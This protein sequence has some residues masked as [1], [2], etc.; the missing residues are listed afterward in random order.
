MYK[1]VPAD[2]ERLVDGLRYCILVHDADTKEILWA[3]KAATDLLGFTVEEL[4]PLKAP[5]MS[6]QE[7][8]YRRSVGRRWLQDAVDNGVA[9]IEWAYRSKS[10]RVILSEAIAVHVDLA[11]RS[12]VM[13]QFRDIEQEAMTRR[14]LTRTE[15][16]LTRT[17][18]RLAAFLRNMAEGILVLDD[19]SR[20]SYASEAAAALLKVPVTSLIGSDFTSF[21][22]TGPSQDHIRRALIATTA[23]GTPQSLRYEVDLPGG[24]RRWHAASCQHIS[25][26]NDLSGHLVLF[27]DITDRVRTEQ[28]HERDSQYLNYLARYNAMGDMAMAIAHELAQP[29]AAATNFIAGTQSRLRDTQSNQQEVMWGLREARQQLDR[30]NEIVRSLREYVTQLEESKQIVDLNEIL[31]ECSYFIDLRARERGV[32]VEYDY[33]S[34]PIE[35]SCERVLT[36]QVILNLCFNAIDEMAAWPEADRLVRIYTSI[37]GTDGELSVEDNGTGIAHIPDGRIFDGA[38]T[39][40]GTGHGIGLALSHRIITRQGG[41]IRAGH[42]EPHGAIFTFSLPI[43]AEQ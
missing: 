1:L 16:E 33:F 39:S 3:N 14:N 42:R 9:V 24:E 27:H 22:R 2:Y 6:A 11:G 10:G 21:C 29:L 25:I 34:T 13:V 8:Q 19:D 36:G 37:C 15:A 26:E 23:G 40:K 38:F 20:I 35:I 32:R 31:E 5:D 41:R 18:A 28:D 4:L 7:E 12:A 30:A 17:E 43:A